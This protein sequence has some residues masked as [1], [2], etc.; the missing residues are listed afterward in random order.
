MV[1]PRSVP[2]LLG[3]FL[4]TVPSAF[5]QVDSVA[6]VGRHPWAAKQS[7]ARG[8][9]IVTLLPWQGRLLA[10]YGD[11]GANTGPITLAWLDPVNG[12]FDSVWSANTEEVANY[13]V[14]ANRIFAPANDRRSYSQPGDYTV[15]DTDG[16]WSNRDCGSTTH[17]FDIVELSRGDLFIVGSQSEKAAVFR[18]TDDGASWRVVLR[19]TAITGDTNDFA[20]FYFA[21]VLNGR[22]YVQARDYRGP[23][24]PQSLVFDGRTW[25][26]GPDLFPGNANSLGWRADTIANQLVYRT[27]EP[28]VSSRLLAFDGVAAHWVD[29][30]RVR[31]VVVSDGVCHVLADS[32]GLITI[33]R[34]ADLQ[35]WQ[36]VGVVPAESTC[37]TIMGGTYYL[38]TSS[39][40]I[41]RFVGGTTAVREV[42]RRDLEFTLW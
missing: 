7:T 41:L 16:V 34:S 6:Q 26:P 10:G 13:R 25:S 21:G 18:S 29:S 42:S 4:L 37:L 20:R 36:R 9:A 31:D 39:S 32:A 40:D 19:D 33:R 3:A 12:R 17:A 8:R 22:L 2:F 11:Y 27:W 38:G 15:L 24:H 1:S 35:T 30:L 5:C 14:I 28:R 23:M